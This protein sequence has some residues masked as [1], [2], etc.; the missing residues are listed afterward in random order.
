MIWPENVDEFIDS[1]EKELS[2]M[3]DDYRVKYEESR[4]LIQVL[5]HKA[6][7]DLWLFKEVPTVDPSNGT[8]TVR[9]AA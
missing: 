7:G 3:G 6:H 9:Y 4:G 2:K 5:L 8:A 1:L